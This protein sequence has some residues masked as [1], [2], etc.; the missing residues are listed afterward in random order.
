MIKSE[1]DWQAEED[2][3]TLRR[4]QEI[5]NDKKR[6]DRALKAADKMVDDLEQRA[7]MLNKSITGFK[8]K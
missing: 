5:I 1:Q 3:N 7:K 4:Y 2:A 8:K 6:L